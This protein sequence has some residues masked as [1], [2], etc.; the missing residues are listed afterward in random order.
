M[1]S[2]RSTKGPSTFSVALAFAAVYLI[3]GS[4]YLAIRFGVETIPPFIMAGSRF[5]F[6]G[7]LLYAWCR[8]RG[9]ER[10]TFIHWR[11]TAIIGGLLLLCGNGC[12]SWAEKIVSSGA[13]ALMVSTLPIWLV[14]LDW[15]RRDGVRPGWA[16]VTG[17]ALGIAG[18][19]ILVGFESFSGGAPVNRIGAAVLML[20]SL[21]WAVGSLYSRVAPLPKSKWLA[22]AMEMLWGGAMLWLLAA[23]RGDWGQFDMSTVSTRSVYAVLY[24]SVFGSLMG[25]SAYIWL[26]GVTTPARVSTYAFVNPIVA[27]IVGYFLAGEEL[28]ARVLLAAMV[29]ISGVVLIT[30]YGRRS[31][32]KS[33]QADASANKTLGSRENGIRTGAWSEPCG[34]CGFSM[35]ELSLEHDPLNRPYYE[36]LR[37]DTMS[38]GVYQIPA[39]GVDRQ[40]PH[41]ED[42]VY[43]VLEGRAQFQLEGAVHE[44]GPG[45]VLYVPAGAEHRF[46]NVS[47]SLR[48]LVFFSPP[49]TEAPLENDN[50]TSRGRT[51]PRKIMV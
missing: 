6:A 39:G 5:L 43:F 24:L 9:A 40:R 7:G 25:F 32:P 16:E 11:S 26:L 4:T 41:V 3:W 38:V 21:S 12:V 37:R 27:V 51:K 29:I 18:V 31:A 2:A 28:T 23:I 8:F 48:I 36:F 10:P 20:G 14:L 1:T 50:Q 42:E 35:D 49:E 30:L 15:L 47:E 46:Q 22:I 33:A 19:S 34:G 45:S 13:A 44:V 17:L